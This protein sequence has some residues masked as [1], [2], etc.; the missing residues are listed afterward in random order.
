L[1]ITMLLAPAI[2]DAWTF[3]EK[4]DVVLVCHRC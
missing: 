2:P 4:A 3:L 1:Y